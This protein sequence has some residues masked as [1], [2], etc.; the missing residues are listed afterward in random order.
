MKM[1]HVTISTA[2]FD[3]SVNFYQTFC[4]LTIQREMNQPGHH[5]IF[6]ANAEGETCIELIE[7][8]DVPYKGTGISIGF[9]VGDVPAYHRAQEDKGFCPTPIFSP[10][11]HVQFFF[12][13]DPN[14]LEIQFI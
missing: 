11:P 7:T 6:L 4:G 10:N 8:P 12:V 13:E 14:G 9:E 2:K 1:R 5:I 3:E